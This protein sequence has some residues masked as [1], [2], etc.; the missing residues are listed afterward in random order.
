MIRILRTEVGWVGWE[1]L[2]WA[3][4]PTFSTGPFVK[5]IINIFVAPLDDGS[6]KGASAF[7]GSWELS[8]P[9]IPYYMSCCGTR[10]LFNRFYGGGF[11][12]DGF[13]ANVKLNRCSVIKLSNLSVLSLSLFFLK[14]KI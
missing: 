7:G 4:S 8:W 2:C 3:D 13:D 10:W 11:A 14:K 12:F 5:P 6:P 9:H 1:L